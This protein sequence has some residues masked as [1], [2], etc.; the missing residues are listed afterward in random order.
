MLGHRP[1]LFDLVAP[2]FRGVGRI[3]SK[4]MITL[5]HD[6]KHARF[7]AQWGIVFGCF[8]MCFL[9]SFLCGL[10]CSRRKWWHCIKFYPTV[11]VHMLRIWHRLSL[12]VLAVGPPPAQGYVVSACEAGHSLAHCW[13]RRGTCS[14]LTRVVGGRAM[15][16][17][18][19]VLT[20]LGGLLHMCSFPV[21]LNVLICRAHEYPWHVC[22]SWNH[23]SRR[24]SRMQIFAP[25]MSF[26]SIRVMS[27]FN[28]RM[29]WP[30]MTWKKK[31]L[32]SPISEVTFEKESKAQGEENWWKDYS[33]NQEVNR[34][35]IQRPVERNGC[36]N[37]EH[38]IPVE[39]CFMC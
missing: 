27:S 1:V 31:K 26:M 12:E 29:N 5:G 10:R 15:P 32:P 23:C 8:D 35:S 24:K 17:C 28:V 39:D 34:E 19:S 21:W 9:L 2:V 4:V 7:D 38:G 3:S 16:C 6:L 20:L 25:R 36:G 14:W 30:R 37:R 11:V 13:T 18:A 22:A 33:V